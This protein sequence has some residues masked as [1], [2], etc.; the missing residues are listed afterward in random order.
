VPISSKRLEAFLFR[1]NED[2]SSSLIFKTISSSL[3]STYFTVITVLFTVIYAVWR[4][5][6]ADFIANCWHAPA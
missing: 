5:C 4:V 6:C 1:S 3:L 2:C